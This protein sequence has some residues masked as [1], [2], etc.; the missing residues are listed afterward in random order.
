[1]VV[2]MGEQVAKDVLDDR[3]G[4]L[5]RDFLLST[6]VYVE[7]LVLYCTIGARI[8]LASYIASIH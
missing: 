6:H 7:R 5:K 2:W 4:G 1:M 3:E 8:P